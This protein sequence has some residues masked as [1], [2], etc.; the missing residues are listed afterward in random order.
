MI[1]THL[2]LQL[3]AHMSGLCLFQQ[4]GD[5]FLFRF[6]DY[7][8]SVLECIGF[9]LNSKT[10]TAHDCD[11]QASGTSAELYNSSYWARTGVAWVAVLDHLCWNWDTCTMHHKSCSPSS[12]GQ[13]SL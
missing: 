2:T 13:T 11:A 6:L 5:F 4:S 9:I 12:H 8:W 3:L 1:V 7:I 10:Q